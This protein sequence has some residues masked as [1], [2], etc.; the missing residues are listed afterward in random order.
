MTAHRCSRCKFSS[1]ALEACSLQSSRPS[2]TIRLF[3]DEGAGVFECRAVRFG[4]HGLPSEVDGTR[5]TQQST[6]RVQRSPAWRR[7]STGLTSK[8]GHAPS[9]SRRASDHSGATSLQLLHN[10]K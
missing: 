2:R 3:P 10:R 1:S 7:A 4:G 8:C 9:K 6:R 5:A